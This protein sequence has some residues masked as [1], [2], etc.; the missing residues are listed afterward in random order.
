MRCMSDSIW[1]IA[2]CDL[3][4]GT[5]FYTSPRNKTR[6]DDRHDHRTRD[7]RA[8]LAHYL[9]PPGPVHERVTHFGVRRAEL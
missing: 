2:L 3:Y 7:D 6:S 1:C 8:W 4:V 9:G 5:F